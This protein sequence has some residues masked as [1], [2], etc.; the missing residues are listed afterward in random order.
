MKPSEAILCCLLLSINVTLHEYLSPHKRSAYLWIQSSNSKVVNQKRLRPTEGEE[1]KIIET[2]ITV[3][4]IIT[5]FLIKEN[6]FEDDINT[7]R[8]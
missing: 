5:T 8:V 6:G 2:C 1:T 4:L 7:V 3:Q